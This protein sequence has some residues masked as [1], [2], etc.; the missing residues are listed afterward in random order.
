M[1]CGDLAFTGSGP[2]VLQLLGALA[3]VLIGLVL[4]LRRRRRE[5]AHR[6]SSAVLGAALA[7]LIAVG[8][9]AIPVSPDAAQ[10]AC[11]AASV[12]S[13]R[14]VQTSTM[15]GLA[16]NRAPAAITGLVTNNG[17]DDTVIVAIV[18]SIASV[19]T[20]PGAAAGT[21]DASDFTLLAPRMNLGVTL[22][23]GGS[24]PF[25][26]ASIGFQNGLANQNACKGSTVNLAYTTVP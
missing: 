10:A 5:G 11:P 12:N 26:G 9:V 16:P 20:A 22:P 19:T 15:S 25:S 8:I 6:G 2:V 17:S 18:V 14:I 24:T 7:L 1:W 23:P 21:C 3:V 4:V 13:L